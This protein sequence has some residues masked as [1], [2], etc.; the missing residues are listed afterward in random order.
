MSKPPVVNYLAVGSGHFV[1]KS[2]FSLANC[3][4]LFFFVYINN[5]T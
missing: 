3:M 2:K 5:D 4:F 1:K